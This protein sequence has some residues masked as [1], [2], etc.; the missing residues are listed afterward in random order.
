MTGLGRM[1]VSAATSLPRVSPSGPRVDAV[2]LGCT[3]ISRQ[4]WPQSGWTVRAPGRAP[5]PAGTQLPRLV[6]GLVCVGP[7]AQRRDL[8]HGMVRAPPR[9]RLPLCSAAVRITG[10]CS[11]TDAQHFYL[12]RI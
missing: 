10:E 6:S 4:H 12:I 7:G 1:V 8:V 5:G 3:S 9:S 11:K 2:A